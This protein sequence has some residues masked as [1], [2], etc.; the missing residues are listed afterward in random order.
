MSHDFSPYQAPAVSIAQQANIPT[1]QSDDVLFRKVEKKAM[2]LVALIIVPILVCAWFLPTAD[3]SAQVAAAIGLCVL[4]L[5]LAIPIQIYMCI[6]GTRTLT[7]FHNSIAV[8]RHGGASQFHRLDQ[9]TSIRRWKNSRSSS[10][11][12]DAFYFF[13]LTFASGSSVQ[14]ETNEALP[15]LLDSVSRRISKDLAKQVDAGGNVKW[16]PNIVIQKDGVMMPV[17]GMLTR[18]RLVT[19]DEFRSIEFLNH[20]AHVFLQKESPQKSNVDI[21]I[22]FRASNSLERWCGTIPLSKTSLA[23]SKRLRV[24]NVSCQYTIVNRNGWPIG[25]WFKR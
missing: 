8:E 24:A 13:K 23:Q 20:H 25:V 9:V 3:T 2:S 10:Q 5:L 12:F 4:F 22:S 7:L 19:W 16:A 15:F 18:K 17:S 6:K 11:S 1:A 21:Q 14:F